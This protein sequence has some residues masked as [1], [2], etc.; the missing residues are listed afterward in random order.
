[1]PFSTDTKWPQGLLDIFEFH[2]NQKHPPLEYLY[3]GPYR[4]RTAVVK[5]GQ[6]QS[7]RIRKILI[8]PPT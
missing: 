1:M 4:V 2:R 3:F 7:K 6:G 8:L 5:A